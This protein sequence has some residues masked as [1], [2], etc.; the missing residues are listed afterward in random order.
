[1]CGFLHSHYLIPLR[2]KYS[3]QHAILKL[4]QPAFLLRYG[5]PRFTPIQNNR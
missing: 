5:Q 2:P 1:L 3:P 4:P